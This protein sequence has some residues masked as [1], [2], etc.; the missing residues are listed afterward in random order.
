MTN[1]SYDEEIKEII[2]VIL[3]EIPKVEPGSVFGMPGYYV[4]GKIWK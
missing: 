4:N 3:L 1:F 2:D